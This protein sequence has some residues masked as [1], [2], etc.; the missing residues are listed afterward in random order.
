METGVYIVFLVGLSAQSVYMNDDLPSCDGLSY[1]TNPSLYEYVGCRTNSDCTSAEVCCSR[2]GTSQCH[3]TVRFYFQNCLY[4]GKYYD[5]GSVFV[6]NYGVYCRCGQGILHGEIICSATV[7]SKHADICKA[8][9]DSHHPNTTQE[10]FIGNCPNADQL[11]I[12]RIQ[13]DKNIGYLTHQFHVTD[14]HGRVLTYLVSQEIYHICNCTHQPLYENMAISEPDEYGNEGV[15]CFKVIVEDIYPPVF[16]TCPENRM[17]SSGQS[18]SW[19]QPH[20]W[21]NVGVKNLTMTPKIKSGAVWRPGIYMVEYAAVDWSGNRAYCQFSV[22]VLGGHS[23]VT[24]SPERSSYPILTITSSIISIMAIAV[25]VVGAL[26]IRKCRQGSRL[27]A[28]NSF[29]SRL[30]AE[31]IRHGHSFGSGGNDNAVFTVYDSEPPPYDIAVRDKLP[32]YISSDSPPPY[33]STSSDEQTGSSTI[34]GV[35]S[36]ATVCDNSQSQY[37]LRN[38]GASQNENAQNSNRSSIVNIVNPDTIHTV[39]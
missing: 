10:P 4:N 16:R 18:V 28:N 14:W 22:T 39:V 26:T 12:V 17:V 36:N 6:G 34:S 31:R 5:V 2:N 1:N 11:V 21:D 29:L 23:D 8:P 32:D 30:R 9:D 35:A 19:I 27:Q 3:T 25:L 24:D 38:D 7:K 20:V 37:T 13:E 33:E 15:C